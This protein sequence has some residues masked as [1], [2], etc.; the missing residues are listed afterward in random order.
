MKTTASWA[1][2]IQRGTSAK[3]SFAYFTGT[4]EEADAYARSLCR[5]GRAVWAEHEAR[6]W[7]IGTK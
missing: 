4:R 6:A 7:V 5:S 1:I 3:L 2:A